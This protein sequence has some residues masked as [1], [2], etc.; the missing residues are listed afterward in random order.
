M[1]RTPYLFVCLYMNGKASKP[2]RRQRWWLIPLLLVGLTTQ[3]FNFS[4]SPAYKE[5]LDLV[6]IDAGHGGKD[7]GTIGKLVQEKQVA[8]SIARELTALLKAN[9]TIDVVQSRPEDKFVALNDRAKIANGK[10]ADLFISIH[11][12]ANKNRA[13]FG[14]STYALGS[15]KNEGNLSAVRENSSILLEDDHE[16]TYEGFD[17]KSPEA[18]IL[19]TLIQNSHQKQ[20]LALAAEV[21]KKF[22]AGGRTSRGVH[23]AGFLVLW[24]TSMPAILVETGFITNATEEKYLASAEGQKALAKAIYQAVLS[25]KAAGD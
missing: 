20:S 8:L 11:V 24:K 16:I 21:E 1:Q 17:P 3:S 25:Y 2:M 9:G 7:P 18:Y 13:A 23:Q 12:N 19:F 14:T 10:K 22:K 5:Y 4:K 15:H 6:V